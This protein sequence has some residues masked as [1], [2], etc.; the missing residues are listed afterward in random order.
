VT[1]VGAV[2][3]GDATRADPGTRARCLSFGHRR[4]TAFIKKESTMLQRS[5]CFVPGAIAAAL[6]LA[7]CSPRDNQ[8]VGQQVDQAVA[9]A[10]ASAQEAA[11][12]AKQA[13]AEAAN[14]VSTTAADATITT[15]INA[16]LAADDKLKATKIDVD[17]SNGRV[18]L[19]GTA[20][21]AGSKERAT[22]LSKAVEGVVDVDNRLTVEAKG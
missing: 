13:T 1:A 11:Q 2:R 5:I 20:P 3:H 6:A 19:T 21:D 17:T 16:A 22:T 15:K 7:A 9:S 8:T 14:A 10:K 4:T 18:V 12:D